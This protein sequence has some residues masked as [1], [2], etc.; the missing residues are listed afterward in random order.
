M[1]PGE[2]SRQGPLPLSCTHACDCNP[3]TSSWL[4]GWQTRH[5]ANSSLATLE[6]LQP[7][8]R[9]Y[10]EGYTWGRD[11]HVAV[12]R[13]H[14][15]TCCGGYYPRTKSKIPKYSVQ[16]QKIQHYRTRSKGEISRR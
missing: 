1:A 2:P 11:I 14:A 15:T 8:G 9:L 12:L 16:G 6:G 10:L 5:T 4:A 7:T 13:L 3:K